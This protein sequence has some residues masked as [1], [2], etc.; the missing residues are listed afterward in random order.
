[1]RHWTQRKAT[2]GQA[3]QQQMSWDH[4]QNILL[5][6]WDCVVQRLTF[7]AGESGT[8]KKQ[9]IS[10]RDRRDELLCATGTS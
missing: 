4:I 9:L 5:D 7:A 3:S 2:E 1:M 6:V 10:L 8:T